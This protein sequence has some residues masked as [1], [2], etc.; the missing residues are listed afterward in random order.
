MI[1]DHP[2]LGTTWKSLWEQETGHELQ[3]GWQTTI[4]ELRVA[5]D[6]AMA[7]E[8]GAVD[9]ATAYRGIIERLGLKEKYQLGNGLLAL[10][11]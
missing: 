2:S 6:L 7:S 11:G 1:E 3:E 4:A 10:R 8:P 5:L 9:A